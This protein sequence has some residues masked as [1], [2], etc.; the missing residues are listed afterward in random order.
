[1]D[2][3]EDSQYQLDEM[4]ST[5][6]SDAQ[7][8]P[9]STTLDDIEIHTSTCG[10]RCCRPKFMQQCADIR[11]FTAFL[12][13][14][15][16]INGAISASYLPSV[17]TAIERRFELS[18]I[19]IGLVVAS[20]EVGAIVAVIFVSY[21]GNERHIPLIIGVMTVLVGAGSCLFALPHF[22]APPY[23]LSLDGAANTTSAAF[24]SANNTNIYTSRDEECSSDEQTGN[25]LYTFI[26]V[27]AQTL[28]GVG[29]APILTLGLSYIDSHVSK[30]AS[31]QYLGKVYL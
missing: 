2:E 18:S 7:L 11:L 5:Q 20:Y 28:I 14:L 6:N 9:N 26:F 25:E 27:L 16:C 4:M 15:S 13:L 3:R 30:K 10:F 29:S 23:T 1:M 31:P 21:L 19:T 12:C 22:I 24:C 17:I 8:M